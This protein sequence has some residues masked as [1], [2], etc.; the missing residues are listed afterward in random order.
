M[1][2]SVEEALK[3][4]LHNK[5]II[6]ET[7]TVYGVGCL[8]NDLDSVK[9]IYELKRREPA[10]PM[11]LL[12]ANW[13]QVKLLVQAYEPAK[14]WA[15]KYWPGALTLVFPKQDSVDDR[16]TAN[17]KTVGI[18]IPDSKVALRLLEKF[19]PMVVTSLNLSNEPAILT[20]HDALAFENVVD[21]IVKG[22]D[23]SG[24]ASTVYDPF[25]HKIY[26]QGLVIIDDT[27][28]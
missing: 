1:I 25:N 8:V 28:L 21:F 6:F 2:L 17:Q 19:G 4:S 9:R 15:D 5:V 3:Q 27:S 24:I 13:D 26:R 10:K 23:L 14:K 18:R 7:D 12:C 16:I 22:S 11:A 20:F